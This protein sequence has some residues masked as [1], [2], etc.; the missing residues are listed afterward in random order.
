MFPIHLTA[1][2]NAF[3]EVSFTMVV[4]SNVAFLQADPHA[5]ATLRML[6]AFSFPTSTT[7]TALFQPSRVAGTTKAILYGWVASELR[8]S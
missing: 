6:P 7:W 2:T 5:I 1:L 4:H 8:E 3:S